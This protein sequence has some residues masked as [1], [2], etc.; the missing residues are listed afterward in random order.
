MAVLEGRIPR[1]SV[2]GSLLA[3]TCEAGLRGFGYAFRPDYTK[4]PK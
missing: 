1:E 2:A 3:P 4:H